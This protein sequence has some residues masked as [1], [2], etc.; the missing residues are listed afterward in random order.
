MLL[1]K[2]ADI[3]TCPACGGKNVVYVVCE[4]N[5]ETAE[6]KTVCENCEHANYWA[7]GYYEVTCS[8]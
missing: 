8:C 5:G 7:Y 2:P 3:N 6:A 1:T 4:T